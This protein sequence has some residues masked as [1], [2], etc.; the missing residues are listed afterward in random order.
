MAGV[1]E[2]TELDVWKLCDALRCRVREVIDRPAFG[3]HPKLREQLEEAAESPCPNIAEGFGRFYPR[4]NALP[5]CL[6]AQLPH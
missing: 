5:H 4:D 1:R 6:I 3:R 2:H